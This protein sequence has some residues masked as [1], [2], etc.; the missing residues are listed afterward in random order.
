MDPT[1]PPN[2]LEPL[3]VT[4]ATNAYIV[5]LEELGLLAGD[6]GDQQ[7]TAE[8]REVL[9]ALHHVLAG[10]QVNIEVVSAGTASVVEDLDGQLDQ[11]VLETNHLNVILDPGICRL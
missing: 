4:P 3:L 10:G 11:A 6:P 8:T 2:R 9:S 1:P 5:Q 7:M